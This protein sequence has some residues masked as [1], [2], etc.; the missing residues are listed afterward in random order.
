VSK[1]DLDLGTLE[2]KDEK[3]RAEETA[4]EYRD[5][6]ARVKKSLEPR[7]KDVRVTHRLTSSPACLVADEHGLGANL[8]RLLKSAGQE[9]QASPPILEINPSHPIVQR[10]R[11]QDG[12]ARFDDWARILYDQALLSEG[13]KLE[14]PAGFVRRLNEMF[15]VV[16]EGASAPHESEETH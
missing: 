12:D 4:G 15:L 2:D 8:E 14:D 7:V 13:G 1:G 9:V 11:D 5:L 3:K 16:A 10:L 6:I